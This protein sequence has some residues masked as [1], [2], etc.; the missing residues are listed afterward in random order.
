MNKRQTHQENKSK[1]LIEIGWERESDRLDHWSQQVFRLKEK[2]G[3]QTKH[4][5]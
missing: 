2:K 5:K 4:A 3:K 1:K